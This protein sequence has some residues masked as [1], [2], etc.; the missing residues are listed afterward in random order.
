MLPTYIS[1]D[2]FSESYFTKNLSMIL[3]H[4]FLQKEAASLYVFQNKS[5][6]DFETNFVIFSADL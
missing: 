2:I 4:V 6:N 5:I 3:T 1:N